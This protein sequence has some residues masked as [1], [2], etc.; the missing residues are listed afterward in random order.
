MC[1][2]KEE[3]CLCETQCSEGEMQDVVHTVVFLYSIMESGIKW[4][5]ALS[6]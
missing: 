3:S 5:L 4:F 6:L 1:W 2:E